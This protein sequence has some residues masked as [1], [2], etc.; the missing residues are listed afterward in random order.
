MSSPIG[1]KVRFRA[2]LYFIQYIPGLKFAADTH[3]SRKDPG[4]G[5]IGLDMNRKDFLPFTA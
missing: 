5:F 1:P 2:S 3:N 4:R